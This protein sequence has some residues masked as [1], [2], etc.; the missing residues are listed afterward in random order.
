MWSRGLR[1][2]ERTKRRGLLRKADERTRLIDFDVLKL[3]PVHRT[4]TPASV[5][6]EAGGL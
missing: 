5:H 6:D 2:Y 1:A 3:E 4:L